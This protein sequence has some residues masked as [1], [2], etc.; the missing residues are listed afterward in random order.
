[1]TLPH[2]V[3]AVALLLLAPLSSAKDYA[4]C[5][6]QP[7]Y[8]PTEKVLPTGENKTVEWFTLNLDLPAEQRWTGLVKP[9][10]KQI[11]R[12]VDVV[13]NSIQKIIGEKRWNS[14]SALLEFMV[15][16]ELRALPNDY[17]REIKGM[18]EATGIPRAD[19]FILNMAYEVWGLCTSMVIQDDAGEVWHGRNLDFGLFPAFDFKHLQWTM[20]EALRPLVVNVDVQKGGKTLYKSTSYAGFA[21]VITGLKKGGF[22]I[23][24][25]SRF[26]NKFDIGLIK[27]LLG[28][29][30]HQELTFTVRKTFEDPSITNYIQA[31]N[32]LN[33]T[34]MIG[35]SYIIIGGMNSGEGAVITK[36][37]ATIDVMS[38]ADELQKGSFFVLETNYDNWKPAPFF[39]DRRNPAK[40]CLNQLTPKGING[41]TGL[42]N[43]LSAKPNL[44]KL[45]TYTT[46]MNVKTGAFEAYRQHCEGICSFW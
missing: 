13:I 41:F 3:Q 23:S 21:G 19:L 20:T 14:T 11:Q 37:Q 22:S 29:H 36:E 26:D 8:P 40:E 33:T 1:M 9:K 24:V 38:L 35:P 18:S 39:D 10:A 43:V 25:D 42:Y 46:L 32:F 44:N 16:L 7:L 27:W 28:D 15:D 6:I 2:L 45:T 34:T 30:K 12:L 5:K 31:F 4:K 17:G